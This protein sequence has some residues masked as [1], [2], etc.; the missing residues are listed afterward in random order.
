MWWYGLVFWRRARKTWRKLKLLTG[1]NYT[2]QRA[3]GARDLLVAF[4]AKRENARPLPNYGFSL[5]SDLTLNST[6]APSLH[7]R[8]ASWARD[9]FALFIYLLH[10]HHPAEKNKQNKS[11]YLDYV[12]AQLIVPRVEHL[13]TVIVNILL[14]IKRTIQI[15]TSIRKEKKRVNLDP[16]VVPS[17]RCVPLQ[18][19][20]SSS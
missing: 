11:I 4:R 6:A 19:S 9:Y 10:T 15:H 17:S 13:S 3:L 7:L 20:V 12:L 8:I 1:V 18:S 14:R 5:R 16:A 2:Q